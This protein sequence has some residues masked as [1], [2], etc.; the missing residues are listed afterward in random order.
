MSP[1]TKREYQIKRE[2]DLLYLLATEGLT[3]KEL[4]ERVGITEHGVISIVKRLKK[5]HRVSNRTQ[6][7]IVYWRGRLAA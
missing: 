1:L 6:L 7:V 2:A 5:R 4:A 3:D